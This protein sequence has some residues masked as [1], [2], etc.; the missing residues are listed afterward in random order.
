[1]VSLLSGSLLALL[2][3]QGSHWCRPAPGRHVWWAVDSIFGPKESSGCHTTSQ[4]RQETWLSCS[5]YIRVYEL[6][7]FNTTCEV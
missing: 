5:Y 6:V 7:G 1:M 3:M 2:I 4:G